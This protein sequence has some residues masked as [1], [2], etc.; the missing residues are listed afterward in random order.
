MPFIKSLAELGHADLALAGGKAASLGEFNR[1]GFPVP[2]GFCITTEAYRAFVEANILQEEILRLTGSME[3]DNPDLLDVV[4]DQIRSLFEAGEI[5]VELASEI[6]TAYVLLANPQPSV[7][8]RS[9]ATAEDL[10]GA[11]FAGQQD[12]Y[13]NISGEEAVLTAVRQ[14]W[15]SLWTARAIGYRRREGI[16]PDAVALAVVVQRLVPADAAGVLFTAN[17]VSGARDEVVINAAWGL[18]EAVVSGLVT[19]DHLV[20]DKASGQIKENRVADKQVMTIRTT[21]GTTEQPVPAAQRRVPALCDSQTAALVDLARRIE[22]HAGRPMDIEWAVNDGQLYVLQARP[23][24]TLE[25]LPEPPDLMGMKWSREILIERYPD[26]I[27]PFS[28]SVVNSSLLLAFATTFRVFGVVLPKGIP[29]FRLIY[30]R[31]YINLTALEGVLKSMPF[32]SPLTSKQPAGEAAK[33]PSLGLSVLPVLWRLL[34]IVLTTHHE[35]ERLLPSFTATVD[36]ESERPWETMSFTELLAG[37]TRQEELLKALMENHAYAIIAAEIT[38]QILRGIT[39]TW[40]GDQ[41]GR[42]AITLLSGLTGNK[43]VETNRALWRLAASTRGNEALQHGIAEAR[44]DDWRKRLD[45]IPGAMDFLA[46]FD[47][48][49][50]SYGHRSPR[51]EMSHPCWSEKPEQALELL[52]LYLNGTVE[53]PGEGEIRKATEREATTRAARQRLSPLRRFVFDRALALAQIYF[54][55]RENQ[56]FYLVM[57]IP[58][59][60]RILHTLGRHLCEAGML[61]KVEDIYFLENVEMLAMVA[62]LAGLPEGSSAPLDSI[63]LVAKRRVEFAR[64]WKVNAPFHLGD[65]SNKQKE[66]TSGELR[67]VP[68]SR[69]LATGKARLVHGPQDFSSVRQG[70][71]IIAPATTPAWTPL[72]GVAGGLVTEFGGLLSHSGVVAREYGLPA[73]LGVPDAMRLIRDGDEITVDGEQ[74]EVIRA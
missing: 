43:T 30:N 4:S 74:G 26:P 29:F 25:N 38:L 53:D 62:K 27:T 59:Q 35:W 48:F 32:Q 55:L 39:S 73:V 15:A 40:L 2:P 1:A 22:S 47:T 68:A 58:L 69:G 13:L 61:R 24:T 50:K 31:P 72:F 18:G 57:A 19:P 60:H 70:E 3:A 66:D 23:I 17:P 20:V 56:Q 5:P 49:L 37:L 41:D 36:Q 52:Q 46:T 67:G 10:P 21:S 42:L 16:L 12:T 8:V 64:S 51:Y 28:W 44:G 11:S 63:Q 14:C 34:K 7:A 65:K 6:R 71:I 33:R 54:R 45:G 9:S